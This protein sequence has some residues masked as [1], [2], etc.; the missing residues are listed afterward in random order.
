M[1]SG[2]SQPKPSTF[3]DSGPLDPAV[4][5]LFR[6]DSQRQQ[7]SVPAG[8]S[9]AEAIATSVPATSSNS[10]GNN[11][12]DDDGDTMT[13]MISQ[14]SMGSSDGDLDSPD[15]AVVNRRLKLLQDR[16]AAAKA[17]RA[18]AILQQLNAA[19]SRVASLPAVAAASS[20]P[21][22]G[23]S[24]YAAVSAL[25]APAAAAA[26]G[27]AASPSPATSTNAPRSAAAS[28]STAS[29][30]LFQ[31]AKL[32]HEQ[33]ARAYAQILALKPNQ[34]TA[35]KPAAK[36][37]AAAG[38]GVAPRPQVAPKVAPK[39]AATSASAAATAT[40][41]AAVET[42]DPSNLKDWTPPPETPF[43]L[44]KYEEKN[45]AFTCETEDSL[46]V[47]CSWQEVATVANEIE[48]ADVDFS[49]MLGDG[50][51]TL[52]DGVDPIVARAIAAAPL[53]LKKEIVETAAKAMQSLLS[54]GA[55][56][57][58]DCINS[59]RVF[60]CACDAPGVFVTHGEWM[61]HR[62]SPQHV[63]CV[64]AVTET[65]LVAELEQIY[66]EAEN[67]CKMRW[68]STENPL[69]AHGRVCFDVCAEHTA[70]QLLCPSIN[71]VVN[72]LVDPVWRLK[73]SDRVYGFHGTANSAV[74]PIICGSLA[75]GRRTGQAYGIGEY[76][77]AT[78]AAYSIAYAKGHDRFFV[79]CIFKNG[80]CQARNNNQFWVV[81][82][83]AVPR[84]DDQ[85]GKIRF[86]LPVLLVAF[87]LAAERKPAIGLTPDM[88]KFHAMRDARLN[89]EWKT[90]REGGYM[91]GVYARPRHL[92]NI[93][94]QPA[95]QQTAANVAATTAK[96][97]TTAETFAHTAIWDFMILGPPG[98]PIAGAEFLGVLQFPIKYPFAAPTVFFL[99]PNGKFNTFVDLCAF[100]NNEWSPAVDCSMLLCSLAA[101]IGTET[102]PTLDR[103]G[104]ATVPPERIA[105]LAKESRGYNDK[106]YR[107]AFVTV[108]REEFSMA[109][110]E[111]LAKNIA[112]QQK[113]NSGAQLETARFF[114]PLP[115]PSARPS[116]AQNDDDDW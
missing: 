112:K 4:I 8:G 67:F 58:P 97:P 7:S 96:S 71:A 16:A 104:A 95:A 70:K 98:S 51:A 84:D 66:T 27:A 53:F 50:D 108:L 103:L 60:I 75:T 6:M 36:P 44:A 89:K 116:Y 65:R 77:S 22:D 105:R 28:R 10:R 109:I 100:S 12:D 20:S 2:N 38:K 49:A 41:V 25:R 81:N 32:I 24:A 31:R 92:P 110:S 48:A 107:L 69:V 34:T 14:A 59:T 5:A 63:A 39:P 82:N 76:F 85:T 90:L 56:A 15:P 42:M 9:N 62:K 33:R 47:E 46:I 106:N 79:F 26:A 88:Q 101:V 17:K 80:A 45:N 55:N 83:P 1:S 87:E 111:G 93:Y 57:W 37:A 68:D 40:A 43:F 18:A 72:A 73:L 64:R 74:A 21:S 19:D 113:V 114:R 52:L 54:S 61:S 99:T 86:M 35:A 3:A 102:L 94:L 115:A 11:S 13:G 78:S 23:R 29:L 91:D 30:T